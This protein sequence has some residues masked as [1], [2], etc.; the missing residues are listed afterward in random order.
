MLCIKGSHK[1]NTF[2][3]QVYECV[4]Q[5]T[6]P[7]CGQISEILEFAPPVEEWESIRCRKCNVSSDKIGRY[8]NKKR[9]IPLND[10]DALAESMEENLE[11]CTT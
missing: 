7:H 1:T 4:G 3:G 10:P 5:F 6:C 9:F 2:T 8:G 11:E